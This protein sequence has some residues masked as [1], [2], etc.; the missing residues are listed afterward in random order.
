M[1]ATGV[2]KYDFI[3]E[4]T[5]TFMKKFDQIALFL[6]RHWVVV[7]SCLLGLFVLTPFLSPLL[8][9]IGWVFPAKVIYWVYSFVCH[10]LPE[11]SYFLFGP[12]ISYSLL[13][14]QSAWQNTTDAVILR[15]FI[16]NPQMGWKMAWSDRMFSMFTSIWVFGILWGSLKKKIGKLPW[17][18]A[19]LFILPMAIDGTTHLISDF[20]GIGQGF[21]DSNS[22][23]AIL[24]NYTLPSAFYAGDAWGSF[25]A[26]MRL[27][28]GILFGLGSVWFGFPLLQEWMSN[29]VKVIDDKYEYRK[30]LA[31]ENERLLSLRLTRIQEQVNDV[32]KKTN[33]GEKLH[34]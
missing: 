3:R 8:M 20:V 30:L 22:W 12:K 34:E 33:L 4:N 26:W 18:G 29:S 16:G 5:N 19:F 10:Q 17:W 7:V 11:R 27:I 1:P 32:S 14:I 2:V 15:Q 28:S 6:T 13:E 31:R 23:L 9:S 24:T 21:R 25:N